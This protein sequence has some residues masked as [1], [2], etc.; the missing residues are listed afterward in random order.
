MKDPYNLQR[1][2]EAQSPVYEQIVR[3]LKA[4]EKT[5][6]WM[7]FIFPQ[8]HSLGQSPIAKKYAIQSKAEA[9]AYLEHELLGE[10]LRECVQLTLEV[11]GRTASDI[12][13][14]IDRLKLRSSLTLFRAVAGEQPIFQESL[15]RHFE[16]Q[17]DSAT[18]AILALGG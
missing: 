4:G 1:F 2:V 16:G 3:E 10:R 15:G 5:T 17:A 13:G 11:E 8:I 7:W 9:S 12:F 18:I 14:Q 6:H